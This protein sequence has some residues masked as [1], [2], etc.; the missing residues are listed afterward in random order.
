MHL[1]SCSA[2]AETPSL[3]S[4]GLLPV[5]RHEVLVEF[6]EDADAPVRPN[7]I[8]SSRGDGCGDGGAAHKQ[9]KCLEALCKRESQPAAC[10]SCRAH[11]DSRLDLIVFPGSSIREQGEY[12]LYLLERAGAYLLL[13]TRLSLAYSMQY[14]A[15]RDAQ[16]QA[17]QPCC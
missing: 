17:V 3:N 4:P 15:Y 6:N 10:A 7:V 13:Q 5:S 14:I 2:L 11:P 12:S 16:W 9:H 1:V 8:P